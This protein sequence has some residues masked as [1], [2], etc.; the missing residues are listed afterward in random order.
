ML[1]VARAPT[2]PSF[3]FAEIESLDISRQIDPKSVSG[4]LTKIRSQ[5][6]ISFPQAMM[7]GVL[8]CAAGFA[9]SIAHERT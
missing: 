8:S 9:I 1:I 7:W 3:N 2:G 4:Q 6:D 5:W